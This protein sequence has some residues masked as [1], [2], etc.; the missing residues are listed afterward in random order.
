MPHWHLVQGFTRYTQRLKRGVGTDG[1]AFDTA[2]IYLFHSAGCVEIAVETW[3]TVRGEV[4]GLGGDVSLS[5]LARGGGTRL[6]TQKQKL[7][8]TITF[9]IDSRRDPGTVPSAGVQYVETVC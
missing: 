8:F 7:L 5:S 2:I 9:Q 1:E 3:T 4:V 6:C